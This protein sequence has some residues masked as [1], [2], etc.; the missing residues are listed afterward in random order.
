MR[1][2][3]A[4]VATN[5]TGSP[6][7]EV[8]WPSTQPLF[9]SGAVLASFIG[10]TGLVNRIFST[11]CLPQ[12]LNRVNS[13]G[14]Y[15]RIIIMFL[16]LCISILVVSNGDMSIQAGVYTIS[17]LGVM[18]LFAIGNIP[19]TAPSQTTEKDQSRLA[20]ISTVISATICGI[21][22]GNIALDSNKFIFLESLFFPTV[23]FVLLTL[24]STPSTKIFL[25]VVDDIMT[26]FS[27]THAKVKKLI[28]KKILEIKSKGLIFFYEG[29]NVASL[30]RA[31]LYIRE[32]ESATSV[33]IIHILDK[34]EV[35]PPRLVSDLR[36]LDEIC[37]S[38][39]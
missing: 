3:L 21:F 27:D 31:L 5:I 35:P 16:A 28:N 10:V 14:R 26:S 38:R 30:N 18:C 39:R 11:E 20:I 25:I 6:L 32:N 15:H 12:A 37:R 36:L 13:R 8:L 1:N 9:L 2:L 33:T 7:A 29:D 23:T 4:D 19:K 34:T 24:S 17:F 22:F